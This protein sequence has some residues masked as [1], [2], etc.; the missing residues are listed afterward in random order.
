MD[1]DVLM[2][3]DHVLRDIH[4]EGDELIVGVILGRGLQV[5][6]V[7]HVALN[8]DHDI[9]VGSIVGL[10]D[11]SDFLHIDPTDGIR[12]NLDVLTVEFSGVKEHIPRED[13]SEAMDLDPSFRK[14][15]QVRTHRETLGFGSPTECVDLSYPA[16]KGASG[17]PV[18]EDGTGLVV[19]MVVSNVER[20]LMPAQTETVYHSDGEQVS[21]D[22]RYFLPSGLAVRA[23]HL[24]TAVWPTTTWN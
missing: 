24:R 16:L 21:E 20:H 19:G 2:T 5:C 4:L 14:G 9:A 22:I 6:P 18:I 1:H 11:D 12:Y 17:A 3:A 15:H 23:M 8:A 13:G 7:T 10:P